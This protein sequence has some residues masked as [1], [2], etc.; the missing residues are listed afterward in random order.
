MF[1]KPLLIF[2]AGLQKQSEISRFRNGSAHGQGHEWKGVEA[3]VLRSDST[4]EG[5]K[6]G[7]DGEVIA[8][9][10]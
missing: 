1:K 10:E 6:D 5:E 2:T 8:G 3:A 9:N 4:D 7:R